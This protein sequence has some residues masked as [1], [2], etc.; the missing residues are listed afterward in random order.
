[1][2]AVTS[3]YQ[4]LLARDRRFTPIDR[5]FGAMLGYLLFSPFLFFAVACFT[6]LAIPDTFLVENLDW[7]FLGAFAP[8]A[9]VIFQ[10]R[11]GRSMTNWR[12]RLTG[13]AYSATIGF[14]MF[15][16]YAAMSAH[17]DAVPG[18]VERTFEF[19]VPNSFGHGTHL[20]HQRSDGTTIE[21]DGLGPVPPYHTV[22][23]EA[24]RLNGDFGFSWVKVVNRSRPAHEIAWPIRAQDCFSRKPLASL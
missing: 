6:E 5:R 9:F 16:V 2:P 10:V 24:Q 21:G 12:V 14:A 7:L 20:V 1:M 11:L 22:C 18:L 3:D 19:S 23:A 15:Y 4:Q 17:A 13:L 8:I